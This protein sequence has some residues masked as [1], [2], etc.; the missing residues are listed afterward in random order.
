MNNKA[1]INTLWKATMA[2]GKSSLFVSSALRICWQL[3][4]KKLNLK[5]AVCLHW[6]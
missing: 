2:K 3:Q 4:P 5:L 6:H 1:A